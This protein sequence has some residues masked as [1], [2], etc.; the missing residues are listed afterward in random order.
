[1]AIMVDFELL[2]VLFIFFESVCV[3]PSDLVKVALSPSRQLHEHHQPALPPPPRPSRAGF[4][5]C[6]Y[7][8]LVCSFLHLMVSG[9]QRTSKSAALEKRLLQSGR[10]RGPGKRLL[11][12]EPR[13]CSVV[14]HYSA[15]G[16]CMSSGLAGQLAHGNQL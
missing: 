10:L 15:G 5:N 3:P 6:P 16:L 11:S 14:Q 4:D 8:R 2:P 7:S 9:N 1:M 13:P 12:A